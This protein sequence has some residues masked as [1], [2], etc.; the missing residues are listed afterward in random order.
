[1][2]KIFLGISITLNIIAAIIFIF[3]YKFSFKGFM[4]KFEKTLINNFVDEDTSK[5]LNEIYDK[6]V[7]NNDSK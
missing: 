3:M 5:Y 4:K 6:K 1:M 7:I 2:L